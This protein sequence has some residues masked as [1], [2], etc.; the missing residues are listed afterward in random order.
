M[1]MVTQRVPKKQ[2]PNLPESSRDRESQ[3]ESGHRERG[4]RF[5]VRDRMGGRG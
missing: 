1:A 4:W 2:L 3:M 5:G